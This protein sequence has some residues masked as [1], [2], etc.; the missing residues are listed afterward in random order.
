M[1]TVSVIF[2]MMSSVKSLHVLCSLPFGICSLFACRIMLVKVL[3]AVCGFLGIMMSEKA[4]SDF[5]VL[6]P[7]CFPITSV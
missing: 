6:F 2:C 7:I 4:A 3:L 5:S 1:R